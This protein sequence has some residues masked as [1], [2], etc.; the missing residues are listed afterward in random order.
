MRGIEVRHLRGQSTHI[1]EN[2][3][4]YLLCVNFCLL[5]NPICIEAMSRGYTTLKQLSALAR[6]VGLP[7]VIFFVSYNRV[8]KLI[9]KQNFELFGVLDKRFIMGARGKAVD[10]RWIR[11]IILDLSRKQKIYARY[12]PSKRLD[13]IVGYLKNSKQSTRMQA[14]YIIDTLGIDMREFRQYT[15]KGDAFNYLRQRLSANNIHVS[16]EARNYMPQSIP[17][18]IKTDFSGVY[19][20]DPKNPSVFICNE[21]SGSPELGSGRKIYTLV[22]LIVCLFKDKSYAV[23]ISR[24][25]YS[26]DKKKYSQL[27]GIHEV[28]N[29]IL[30]PYEEIKSAHVTNYDELNRIANMFNVTPRAA[31]QRLYD[32][33]IV[34]E[35]KTYKTLAEECDR[36]F[37]AFVKKAK[38]RKCGGSPGADIM[39]SYYQGDFLQF[40]Q[41]QVPVSERAALIRKHVAFNRLHT[42]FEVSS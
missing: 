5:E 24:D 9:D 1:V 4:F 22:F 6:S 13:H 10:V 12:H 7:Y 26:V 28:V 41:T 15:K 35:Y 2:R 42:G 14:D 17:D 20:R 29:E 16:V 8:K 39:I 19:I 37:A 34:S 38:E 3:V 33:R 32:K 30:L 11:R 18:Q 40:V 23:S 27:A 25:T 31:L 21:L 36:R